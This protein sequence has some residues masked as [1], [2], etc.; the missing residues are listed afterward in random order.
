MNYIKKKKERKKENNGETDLS[1]TGNS[2]TKKSRK[3]R[4]IYIYILSASVVLLQP[5]VLSFV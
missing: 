3:E 4:N 2:R 5:V 1:E